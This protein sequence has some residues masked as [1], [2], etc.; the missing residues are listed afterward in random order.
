MF[1]FASRFLDAMLHGPH[2]KLGSRKE[3]LHMAVEHKIPT[4]D[5]SH[6]GSDAVPR[7]DAAR[8]RPSAAVHGSDAVNAVADATDAASGAAGA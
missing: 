5:A 7:S 2:A 4:V 3:S 8:T 1:V 6:D